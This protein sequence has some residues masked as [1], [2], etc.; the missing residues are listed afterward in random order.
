MT[1]NPHAWKEEARSGLVLRRGRLGMV[2]EQSG[3]D[4]A[5][6]PDA[7]PH[8]TRTPEDEVSDMEVSIAA[9]KRLCADL[10]ITPEVLAEYVEAG[11]IRPCKACGGIGI[12][13]RDRGGW[14]STCRT[15]RKGRRKK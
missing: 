3:I 2:S 14:R 5:A 15:C 4:H 7:A 11:R 9:R 13:D 12:F 10:E 1:K 8:V 6:I